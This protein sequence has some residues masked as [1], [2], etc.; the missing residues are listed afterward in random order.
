MGTLYSTV[1]T[2]AHLLTIPVNDI[3]PQGRVSMQ[4]LSRR[5]WIVYAVFLPRDS[6]RRWRRLTEDGPKPI[7]KDPLIPASKMNNRTFW[8]NSTINFMES[9]HTD[10]FSYFTWFTHTVVYTTQVENQITKKNHRVHVLKYI[11]DNRISKLH[12]YKMFLWLP[13]LGL[14]KYVLTW[15]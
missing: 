15:M 8:K 6:E 10:V 11:G 14:T 12:V 13:Q 7:P 5:W 2:I 3:F 9:L 1:Q 4:I